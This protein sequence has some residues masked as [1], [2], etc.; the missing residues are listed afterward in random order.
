MAYDA[1]TW[2]KLYMTKEQGQVSC[3]GRHLLCLTQGKGTVRG[4]EWERRGE[5]GGEGPD[6]AGSPKNSA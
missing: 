4:G 2:E 3:G 6:H 5:R 1:V